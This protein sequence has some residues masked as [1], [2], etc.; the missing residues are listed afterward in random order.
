MA[1]SSVL[2]GFVTLFHPVRDKFLHSV[3]ALTLAIIYL[4]MV[5]GFCRPTVWKAPL[6]LK[7]LL[8]IGVPLVIIV[9]LW[10]LVR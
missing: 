1:G 5:S 6:E 4:S 9:G 8:L 7:L 3:A 10:P 2:L